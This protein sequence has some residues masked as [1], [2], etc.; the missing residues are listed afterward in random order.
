MVRTNLLTSERP[1]ERPVERRPYD[2]YSDQVLW[3]NRMKVEIQ[4]RYGRK[5]TANAMVQL[6]LDLFIQD[7]KAKGKRSALISNLV[8]HRPLRERPEEETEE[9]SDEETSGRPSEGD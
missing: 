1:N 2:F 9:A 7:Y 8:F 5:V 4:A 3:L 6:A